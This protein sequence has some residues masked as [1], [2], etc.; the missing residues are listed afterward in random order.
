[1]RFIRRF[2]QGM[3]ILAPAFRTLY[4]HPRLLAWSSIPFSITLALYIWAFGPLNEA[5]TS[6]T[7]SF[8]LSLLPNAWLPSS[9]LDSMSGVIQGL[10]TLILLGFSAFT[11]SGVAGILSVP[12]NDFLAEAAESRVSPPLN[13]VRDLGFKDRIRI[14]WTDLKLTFLGL[15]LTLSALILGLIPGL[16]LLS[17]ILAIA[18]I[19]LQYL[20]FPQ[21]RRQLRAR[22]AILFLLHYPAETLGF[23]LIGR[24]LLSIPVLAGFFIP[25]LVI[26]GTALFARLEPDFRKSQSR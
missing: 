9:G 23:G 3:G 4:R 10:S 2:L 7:Q 14:L 17:P 18:G 25:L 15:T 11:F 5:L 13:P 26:A 8:L 16:N 22:D 20:S 19:A 1:M 12:F 21:A 24:I 6:L